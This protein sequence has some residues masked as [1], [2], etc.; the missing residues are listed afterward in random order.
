M[1]RLNPDQLLNMTGIEYFLLHIQAPIL[2]VIRKGNRQSSS[3]I[4]TIC[5]Y[6]II[7]GSVYQAPDLC[8]IVNSRLLNSTHS[9]LSAFEEVKSYSRYHP[10]VGYWWQFKNDTSQSLKKKLAKNNDPVGSFFQRQ[11]VDALLTEHAKKF[12]IKARSQ[13]ENIQNDTAQIDK[14]SQDHGKP[15]T[16]DPSMPPPGKKPKIAH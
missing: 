16:S 10:S 14:K 3:H 15:Q 4:N 13:N 9:L 12:P 7:N 1:Q 5:D 2:Y 11:K 6:Y 8:S